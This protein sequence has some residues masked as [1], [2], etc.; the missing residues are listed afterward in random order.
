MF[1]PAFFQLE[2]GTGHGH[3]GASLR[4]LHWDARK[5]DSPQGTLELRM[6][7][8]KWDLSGLLGKGGAFLV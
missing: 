7:S 8:E 3:Q 5:A 2:Q 1:I 6:M 4:A